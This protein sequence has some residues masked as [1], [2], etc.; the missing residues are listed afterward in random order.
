MK[1]NRPA[2]GDN[3]R[4][5]D[6]SISAQRA[7][8]EQDNPLATKDPREVMLDFSSNHDLVSRY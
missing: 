4:P 2:L 8:F 1:A 5:N 6:V 3:C 7:G